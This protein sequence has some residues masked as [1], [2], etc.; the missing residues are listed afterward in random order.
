[1]AGVEHRPQA[2]APEVLGDEE[3]HVAVAP[4]VDGH[5]VG[6]AERR[7]GLRLGPEPA[8]ERVVLGER[9]VEHLDGHP[10]PQPD[11]VGQVDLR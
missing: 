8:E 1:V 2:A 11:V 4:V 6:M 9:R 3:R 5:D 7:G 10:P